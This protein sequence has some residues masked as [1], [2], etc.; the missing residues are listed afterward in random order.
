ML[1]VRDLMTSDP[2]TVTPETRLRE[3]LATMNTS[4]CR[5][6]PVMEGERL[7]GIITERDLRLAVNSPVLGQNTTEAADV[8][9]EFTTG[10]CMSP[11][12]LTISPDEPAHNVADIL[13]LRKYGALPV[14]EAGRLV[15][16]ISVI[17]FLT[18][19]SNMQQ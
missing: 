4:G 6:L 18:Y 11:D 3:V 12:P 8:L 1:T 14:V 15:G 9:E 2:I 17:D 7:V 16:I 13:R 10:Q 5:H 19:F